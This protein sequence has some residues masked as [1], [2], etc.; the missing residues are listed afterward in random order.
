MKNAEPRPTRKYTLAERKDKR[1]NNLVNHLI[2]PIGGLVLAGTL[3]VGL[4]QYIESQNPKPM[5]ETPITATVPGK[6]MNWL[7]EKANPN[8]WLTAPELFVGDEILEKQA[9][10]G[11]VKLGH[12]YEVPVFQVAKTPQTTNHSH[13]QSNKA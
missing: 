12:T 6:G 8:I 4:Y 11:D 5:K 2:K 10:N 1:R 13:E 3:T 9:P 7:L